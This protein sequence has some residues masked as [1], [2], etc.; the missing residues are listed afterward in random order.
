V[1]ENIRFET[2][3]V[4]ND[5]ET[6]TVLFEFSCTS[7]GTST[8]TVRLDA[9]TI[10]GK[11]SITG[12]VPNLISGLTANDVT[13]VAWKWN[14]DDDDNTDSIAE[15]TGYFE[16]DDGWLA[17]DPRHD[18]WICAATS[19]KLIPDDITTALGPPWYSAEG[20]HFGHDFQM[21]V[22]NETYPGFSFAGL[23]IR[24]EI[25]D[26]D[27]NVK[28]NEDLIN[29]IKTEATGTWTILAD[30]RFNL[31]DRHFAGKN[32]SL[33]FA[34]PN[35]NTTVTLLQVYI[36]TSGGWPAKNP[37]HAIGQ[38]GGFFGFFAALHYIAYENVSMTFIRVTKD[39]ITCDC[40]P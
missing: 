34:P 33:L 22:E 1:G 15:V 26:V 10:G 30:N 39:G 24:E 16:F 4:D 11:W 9:D 21:T 14:P 7:S 32:I 6:T 40:T 8:P 23:G 3:I 38:M 12:G 5:T 17:T 27:C 31:D 37:N 29:N 13:A 36:I 2:Q 35:N 25:M 19:L 28:R 18:E 20:H